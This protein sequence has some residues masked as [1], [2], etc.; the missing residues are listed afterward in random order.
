M[1][2]SSIQHFVYCKRQWALIHIERHWKENLLTVEGKNLHE[3]ADNPFEKETR[4]DLIVSRAMP[5]ISHSLGI[6][7]VADVV[8]FRKV[9]EKVGIKLIGH[10]G[11]W[12]PRPVEYKRGKAKEDWSDEA[13]LCLQALCME[14]MHGVS[15]EKA[16]LYYHQTRRR[17]VVQLTPKLREWTI[18]MTEEMQ[19]LFSKGITPSADKKKKCGNCSMKEVCFP[20]LTKRN[21]LVSSYFDEMMKEGE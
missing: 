4:G 1:P 5:L 6:Q 15:I 3:R 7:G 9:Q 21:R 10:D 16:F 2:L 17:L 13:Q 20:R 18:I 11:F 14:E 12:I 8:E 19:E